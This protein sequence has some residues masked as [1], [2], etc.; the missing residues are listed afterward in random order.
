MK[1]GC[2]DGYIRPI[3]KDDASQ[4]YLDLDIWKWNISTSQYQ[5]IARAVC[6]FLLLDKQPV[7]ALDGVGLKR[8]LE[9]LKPRYEIVSRAY[10]QHVCVSNIVMRSLI[11]HLFPACLYTILI[12]LTCIEKRNHYRSLCC[13]TSSMF[14][15]Q[16][17]LCLTLV[18]M[19]SLVPTLFILS[20][21]LVMVGQAPIMNHTSA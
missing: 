20:L 9:L 11:H 1:A 2:L 14:H 6:E 21:P 5:V 19:C 8:I 17:T 10:M 15:L 16:S 13:I 7:T 18:Q 3:K 4:S 12:F